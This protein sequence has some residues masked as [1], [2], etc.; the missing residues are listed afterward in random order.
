MTLLLVVLAQAAAPASDDFPR[1]ADVAARSGLTLKDLRGGSGDYILEVTGNGAAFFDYDEDGDLDVLTANGSTLRKYRGGG[2]PM[3]TLYQNDGGRFAEVT[4]AAGLARHG[5]AIG[6]CAADYDN[7]GD[8]DFYLTAYGPNVMYRNNGDGTFADVTE[9]AGTGDARWSTNCAFGDYDRDGDVDLYVANYV[10]FKEEVVPKRGENERCRYKGV[11]VFCGPLGLPGER[12]TLYRNNGDGTF[13]DV[14]LEAG[15]TDPGFH[16][17]GVVFSDLDNDGW[18]DIYVANDSQPN[19]LFKNNRNGTFTEIGRFSGTALSGA[20]IAQAGMGLAIGDYNGDGR[21]DIFV[22][23][24]IL[25]TNTLY[26]NLGN[27]DFSDVTATVGVG[28]PSFNHMGWGTAFADLNNDGWQDLFVANGHLLP[29]ID[30]FGIGQHYFQRKE[31]YRNLGDGTFKEVT[32]AA[33]GD[34]Q[35]PRSTRGLALGDFDN[36]GDIDAL[37]INVNDRPSLYRNDGGNRNPWISFRL[38]GTRSNRDAIGARIEITSGGRIQVKEVR[39]GGSYLSH[40]DMRVH[41]GLGKQAG[42][43]SIRIRWPNG[44]VE[45]FSGMDANQFVTIR[46]GA[47]LHD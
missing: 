14:T 13:R 35:R 22:T 43:S 16:G 23:N 4:L 38:I 6:V 9:H 12:D 39:S 31:V 10:K 46:E 3:A 32:K 24:F 33:G 19:F 26:R 25:D 44:N 45:V 7:D 8:H 47:G 18:Q 40:S 28:P 36:D 30:D 27:M 15:I 21:F 29:G 41:F 42:V 5:W 11:D 1:F 20:G 34:V 2:S 37:A 17:F